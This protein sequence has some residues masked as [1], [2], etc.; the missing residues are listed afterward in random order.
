MCRKFLVV[1]PL[2]DVHIGS[3]E[4]AHHRGDLYLSAAATAVAH[5]NGIAS[6]HAQRIG[7][8][9]RHNHTTVIQ[10]HSAAT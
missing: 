2:T 10:R 7:S 9:L 3:D 6:V 8:G 1:Q 5:G 4:V